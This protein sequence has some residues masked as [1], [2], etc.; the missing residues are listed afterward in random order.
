MKNFRPF[1]LSC[2]RAFVLSCLLLSAFCLQ[3]LFAQ[4][5]KPKALEHK[6]TFN[7][8]DCKEHEMLLAI[9]YQGKL[10]K[11]DSAYNNGKGVFI[12]QGDNKYD[13]G[14][15]SLVGGGKRILDFLMD[16]IQQFTYNLDT[17]GN[18]HNF[19]VT[20]SPENTEML[21]FQQKTL[22]AMKNKA[23]WI[24]KRKNF[25]EKNTDSVDY[26]LEKIKDLDS[27]M[28]QFISEI[29]DRNPT[30]LFS[31]FQKS[32]RDIKIPDPPVY[33]DGSIDSSF[34]AVYYRMHYW[35]NFDL[36]DR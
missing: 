31:K 29:I 14:M 8:K 18:L 15:Y 23:K 5:T 19:S 34:Q 9:H 32:N 12:F 35:D 36:T 16:D 24:E 3:P 28:E 11:K 25:A 2:F 33:A 21:R 4:K 30:F 26:Y 1:A 10:M 22:E 17:T 27:E 7:I 13:A 20:G 6:L